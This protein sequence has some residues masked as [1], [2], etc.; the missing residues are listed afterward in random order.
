[1]TVEINPVVLIPNDCSSA[2]E[3]MEPHVMTSISTQEPSE[4]EQET[5]HVV[6][7]D[8]FNFIARKLVSIRWSDEKIDQSKS[9]TVN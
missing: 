6:Q 4:F 7:S 5:L 3:S 2:V 8:L 9:L 1:M